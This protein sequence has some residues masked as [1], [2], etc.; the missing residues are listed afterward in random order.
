MHPIVGASEGDVFT[1]DLLKS[2]SLPPAVSYDK[3]THVLERAPW[4]ERGLEHGVATLLEVLL[5]QKPKDGLRRLCTATVMVPKLRWK[6][7]V[8]TIGTGN[9]A[10]L[11][12]QTQPVICK[13][14]HQF[15][16]REHVLKGLE[17]MGRSARFQ[18]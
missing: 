13:H 3:Q 17:E 9:L 11:K 4:N 2:P 8:Y 12:Y 16:V 14:L 15:P 10:G 5:R 7:D 18:V 6:S 1:T